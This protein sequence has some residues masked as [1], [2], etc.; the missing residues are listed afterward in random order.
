MSASVPAA[1]RVK[2]RP[3]GPR[4]WATSPAANRASARVPSPTV[5]MKSEKVSRAASS[6][7]IENGRRSGGST[8][9]P[10][11]IITNCPA[12]AELAISGCRKVSTM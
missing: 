11:L 1:G 8:E 10:A 3:R 9:M 4:H 12:R 5:L 2:G 6:D 7:S